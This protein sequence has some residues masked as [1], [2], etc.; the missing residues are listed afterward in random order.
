MI[1]VKTF[2]Q[3]LKIFETQK[4]LHQLDEEVNKFLHENNIAKVVSVSDAVLTTTEGAT[5]GVIR[6]VTYEQ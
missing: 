4:E 6:V 2:G 1:K 3:V 5:Q